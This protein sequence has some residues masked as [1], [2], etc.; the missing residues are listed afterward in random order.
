ML[1]DQNQQPIRLGCRWW[2]VPPWNCP[3]QAFDANG[4]GLMDLIQT[5]YPVGGIYLDGVWVP[6]TIHV[7]LRRGQER[8]LLMSVADRGAGIGR[9]RLQQQG[10]PSG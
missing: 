1:L 6:G 8:D 3:L 9:G 10:S 7:Y 4:H 2:S 5:V